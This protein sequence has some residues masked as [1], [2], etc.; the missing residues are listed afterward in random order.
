[1]TN[2]RKALELSSNLAQQPAFPE[3]T[4]GSLSMRWFVDG[5]GAR[6]FAV[7]QSVC[8]RDIA[9]SALSTNWLQSASLVYRSI[10]G[11]R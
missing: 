2:G 6:E 1:M 8:S 11:P 4:A 5:E 3:S 7:R 9:S 10:S